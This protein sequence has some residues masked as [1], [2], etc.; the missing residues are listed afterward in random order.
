MSKTITGNPLAIEAE[1]TA[2]SQGQLQKDYDYHRAEMLADTLLSEGKIS[3]S[4]RALLAQINRQT[5]SPYNADIL[6]KFVD[7]TADQS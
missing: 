7:I 5:F 1:P 3:G 6:P 4:E 2:P